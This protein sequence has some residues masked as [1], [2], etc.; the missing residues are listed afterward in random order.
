M[1]SIRTAA[2]PTPIRV[3]LVEDDP[4]AAEL[5]ISYLAAEG[6]GAFQI[7]WSCTLSEALRALERPNA[8]VVL[9][10]LGLPELTGFR[11][12]RVIETVAGRSLPVVIL[13]SD[14]RRISRE[15][16]VGVGAAGYLLKQETGPSELCRA[17][18][19]AALPL[20]G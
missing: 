1:T 3:L 19:G 2:C 17:L 20:L 5:A 7:E 15:L 18:R 11:T 13:T 12:H 9:L 14:D 10:D 4:D 16:T 8:D 6:A